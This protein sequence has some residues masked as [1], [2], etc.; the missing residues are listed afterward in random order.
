METIIFIRDLQDIK[1]DTLGETATFECELSKEGLKVEW[2]KRTKKTDKKLRRDEKY[3]F[4]TEGGVHRLV[5]DKAEAEDEGQYRAEFEKLTS[6][7]KLS[8]AG[9]LVLLNLIHHVERIQML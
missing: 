9:K 7:A 3:D 2:Y 4:V 6:E 1:L 5:I 8:V